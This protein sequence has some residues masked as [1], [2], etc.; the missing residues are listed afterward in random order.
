MKVSNKTP[1][2]LELHRLSYEFNKSKGQFKLL[3][4]EDLTEEDKTVFSQDLLSFLT[5]LHKTN[6]DATMYDVL[7]TLFAKWGI[8]CSHPTEKCIKNNNGKKVNYS[9]CTIC[10]SHILSS[11]KKKNNNSGNV[12]E[13]AR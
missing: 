4:V 13:N 2:R 5:G 8:M 12:K 11:S 1:G 7:G 3:S 6:P 10:N 9:Y